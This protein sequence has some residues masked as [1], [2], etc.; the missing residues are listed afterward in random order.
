STTT[1]HHRHAVEF[2]KNTPTPEPQHQPGT[3]TPGSHLFVL[4]MFQT[5]AGPYPAG[6][7][8]VTSRSP[9]LNR[10]TVD[11]ALKFS[12]A[13][14]LSAP[15]SVTARSVSFPARSALTERNLQAPENIVETAPH[16]MLKL[17]VTS[18]DHGIT[19]MEACEWPVG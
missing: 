8:G 1:H 10:P 6:F 16:L 11:P 3:K 7:R 4:L 19:R 14:G 17:Q 18:G 15:D 13:R 2:S 12:T 5:L 9:A